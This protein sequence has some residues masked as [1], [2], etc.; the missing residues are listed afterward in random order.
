[1]LRAWFWGWKRRNICADFD[2][3]SPV[4]MQKCVQLY[5]FLALCTARAEDLHSSFGS[6][7][8]HV[9]ERIRVSA[10][11]KYKCLFFLAAY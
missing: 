4:K 3:H 11:A 9:N 1:M 8:T 7:F 2:T 5:L 6:D 10:R